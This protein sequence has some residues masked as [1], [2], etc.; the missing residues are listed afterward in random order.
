LLKII[1]I[2]GI[3]SSKWMHQPMSRKAICGVQG[4][5]ELVVSSGYLIR[6]PI[7]KQSISAAKPD[8][9]MIFRVIN[10]DGEYFAY[11][12]AAPG[13]FSMSSTSNVL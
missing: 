4:V 8:T 6:L 12:L 5:T 3:H 1:T 11:K 7:K 10:R 2:N 13:V 9:C